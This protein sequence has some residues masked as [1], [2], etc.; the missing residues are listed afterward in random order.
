[1]QSM[2]EICDQ[3]P[4]AMIWWSMQTTP[5]LSSLKWTLHH[6]KTNWGTST[7]GRQIITF[8]S[9]KPRR[10]KSCFTP[11]VAIVPKRNCH[12]HCPEFNALAASKFLALP[13]VISCPWLDMSLHCWTPV[14]EHCT[15]CGFSEPTV[16]T[17]TVWTKF[18]AVRYWPSCCTQVLHG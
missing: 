14:K 1:M 10:S 13:S 7:N 18:S 3:S 17:K 16:F 2:P 9:I 15:V 12:H 6:V 5:I 11:E 8:A 4:T